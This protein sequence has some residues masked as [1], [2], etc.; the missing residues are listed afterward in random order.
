M[1]NKKPTEWKDWCDLYEFVKKEIMGY[2][3]DMKLP[4]YMV[5]RLKGLAKGQFLANPNQKPMAS[6]DFKIILYTFK[7]C[8]TKILDWFRL[9]EV[10][11]KDE[12]HK[13]NSSMIFIE[14][15]I[16]DVVIR[17]KQAKKIQEKTENINLEHFAN[18]TAKY[19]KKSK[20]TNLTDLW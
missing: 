19:K 4:Q 18:E 16:N 5:L 8:K 2:T 6:Y 3:P 17:L 9:N 7:I 12:Q 1:S 13:F 11:F 20:D 10:K 14:K 15:E